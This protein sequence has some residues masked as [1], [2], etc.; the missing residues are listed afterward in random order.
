MAATK[1]E[2]R[3][4]PRFPVA[5]TFD[6]HNLGAPLTKCKA[7]ITDLSVSGM[8]F[9]S[10]AVLEEGTALHLTV[11]IPFEIRGLVRHI[12]KRGNLHRYGL[13]F[14]KFGFPGTP[15]KIPDKFIPAT[16]RKK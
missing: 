10:D 3:Q 1:R 4:F 16:V 2:K 8:A 15:G 11:K 14:H 5:L 6:A 9:E 12:S 13:R 7:V